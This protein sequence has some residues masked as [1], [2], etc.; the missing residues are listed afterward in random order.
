MGRDRCSGLKYPCRPVGREGGYATRG[1]VVLVSETADAATQT[2]SVRAEV[3]NTGEL[4]PG[5]TAQARIGFVS[6]AD[7]ASISWPPIAHLLTSD[8]EGREEH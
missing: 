4:R 8:L 2:I 6:S 7:V 1:R 5:Q 3:P